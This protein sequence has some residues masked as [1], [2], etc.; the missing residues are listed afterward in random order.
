MSQKEYYL[1]LPLLLY[2]LGITDLINSWRSFLKPDQRYLPYTLTSI[3]LLDTSFWNFYQLFDWV[4]ED[5]FSSYLVYMKI[6]AAP[7]VFLV[8]VA[9]F[10]PE[11]STAS[12][13]DYFHQNMRPVFALLALFI[14]LHFTLD[15]HEYVWQRLG[16][17]AL[18]LAISITRKTWLIYLLLGFRV[19]TL[20]MA[21]G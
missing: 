10:T 14:F 8:V 16:A 5:H 4:S 2:G 21:G 17:I 15:P 9:I 7:L 11:E 6:L 12:L 13:K 1:I 19:V 18:L 3:L 20:M